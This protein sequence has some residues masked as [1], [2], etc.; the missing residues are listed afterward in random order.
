MELANRIHIQPL[1][2]CI[3]IRKTTKPTRLALEK[4]AILTQNRIGP[5]KF[6]GPAEFEP[7][8]YC[9]ASVNFTS[10]PLI[11]HP[12]WVITMLLCISWTWNGVSYWLHSNNLIS[13][14]IMFLLCTQT[15]FF[16]WYIH[17]SYTP[18]TLRACWSKSK[19]RILKI[20]ESSAR[21]LFLY[22]CTPNISRSA[23]ASVSIA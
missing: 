12:R 14:E 9:T 20:R 3:G 19:F 15:I 7:D 22:N 23:D 11:S 13:Q 1:A 6:P 10:V 17:D 16:L 4:C 2:S 18:R 5:T 21:A 8:T